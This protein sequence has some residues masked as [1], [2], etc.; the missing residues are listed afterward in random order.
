MTLSL[1]LNQTSRELKLFVFVEKQLISHRCSSNIFL[2]PPIWGVLKK[3]NL[4]K[5]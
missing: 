2:K 1:K 4:T 5:T 3:Y